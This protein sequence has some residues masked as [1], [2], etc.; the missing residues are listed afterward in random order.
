M[1]PLL[2]DCVTHD[3]RWDR[4][5][6][7][8]SAYYAALLQQLAL[9][10]DPFDAYIRACAEND[11]EDASDAE[12]TVIDIL[13]ALAVRGD[14]PALVIMRA[15]LTYGHNW[16]DVFE[17]LMEAPGSLLSVDEVSGIIDQRFPDDDTLDDELPWVGPGMHTRQ[18]PWRSLRRVNPR[19]DRILNTREQEAEQRQ[20]QQEL[21]QARLARLSTSELLAL[22]VK[23]HM[24][25]RV[26]HALQQHVTS[27]DLDVLLQRAQ[28]G[29][30]WQRY[31][32]FRGLQRLAH[33]AA[34]PALQAFFES[35]AAQ[36]GS[37]YGAAVRA[38]IALPPSVTLD[39]ARAWFD[40]VD[41]THRHV[42]LC[43]LEEHATATDV[44]RVRAA[45]LPSLER[46][47]RRTNEGYMQGSMLTILA[48]F[49]EASSYPVAETVF[50]EAKYARTRV[51]A[52]QALAAS[53]RDQFAHT[54]ALECLWDCEEQVRVI[55]CNNV[56]LPGPEAASRLQAIAHDLH[57]DEEVRHAA[58]ERLAVGKP[59]RETRNRSEVGDESHLLES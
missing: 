37:L 29:E 23:D 30:R 36:P 15:Y 38:I 3:P 42:A 18:E 57:E 56:D 59:Q 51:Y 39:L 48:H 24:A 50:K 8:R 16:E 27:A 45:L 32:A 7:S 4:Q 11:S 55:G 9:P 2:F 22:D 26:A 12:Y 13:C 35:P 20:H 43:I 54:I 31:I 14:M 21:L 49:P 5:L 28:A 19:V 6:E 10:L 44:R 25:Y 53:D 17:M 1:G 46:D 52:A 40:A 33:P 34:L 58:K 41:G 47:T